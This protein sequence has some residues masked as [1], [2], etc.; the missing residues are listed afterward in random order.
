MCARHPAL[1]QARIRPLSCGLRGHRLQLGHVFRQK[2]GAQAGA[3]AL[4]SPSLPACRPALLQVTNLSASACFTLS[5]AFSRCLAP[6]S[7]SPFL[8][9]P[10]S[11]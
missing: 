3:V 10:Q 6:S 2:C 11:D 9:P 8:R 5:I 4:Q 1:L 7:L